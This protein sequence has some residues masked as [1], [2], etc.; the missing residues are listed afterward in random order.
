MRRSS[1]HTLTARVWRKGKVR[2]P[3]NPGS[4]ELDDSSNF[5]YGLDGAP[6]T[7]PASDIGE[8]N[9]QISHDGNNSREERRP[10]PAQLPAQARQLSDTGRRHQH[11]VG[12]QRWDSRDLPQSIC[13]DASITAVFLFFTGFPEFCFH[14]T[15]KGRR[16]MG[17]A[18]KFMS[19][20][21]QQRCHWA[22]V[23]L[24]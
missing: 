9:N 16:L 5:P 10:A 13:L 24:Q 14:T 21:A 6:N 20:Y 3:S 7:P 1:R 2:A 18:I 17:T 4:S 12:N 8:G 22:I 15:L 19:R 23:C 11:S